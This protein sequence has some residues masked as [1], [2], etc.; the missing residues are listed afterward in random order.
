MTDRHSRPT[1]DD[2]FAERVARPLRASAQAS[3]GFEDSLIAAIRANAPL[4]RLVPRHTTPWSPAWWS[5]TTI[6]LTP[7][8]GLA[9]AA[10]IA[11][12]AAVTSRRIARPSQPLTPPA[13]VA[14][15][16][17][18]DTVTLVRFVFVGQATS[19][20]L[21]GDFNDWGAQPVQLDQTPS[22]AWTASVPLPN[23]RHEYAF[24]VDGKD[25]VA[26]PLAPSTS[27]EFDTQSSIIT[28]G[29]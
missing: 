6:H 15:A 24:I 27:D 18:T 23:G 19:V 20:K 3:G 11:A 2:A 21:V 26:D 13:V 9:L 1:D 29:T 22:G 12:I 10:G 7:L 28:V 4:R 5:A 17:V 8:A 25:W 14:T 16:P